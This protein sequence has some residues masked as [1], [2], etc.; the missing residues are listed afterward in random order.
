MDNPVL[1]LNTYTVC[2]GAACSWVYGIECIPADGGGC[3]STNEN[4][5]T[6]NSGRRNWGTLRVDDVNGIVQ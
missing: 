5:G 2:K 1:E 4:L 3:T 6:G